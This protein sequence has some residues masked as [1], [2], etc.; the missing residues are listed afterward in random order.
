MANNKNSNEMVVVRSTY[1]RNGKK[2]F[3]YSLNGNIN[4]RAKEIRLTCQDVGMFDVLD[5]IFEVNGKPTLVA[6]PF[7]MK[8]D[9]GKE[10]KGF[11]YEVMTTGEDSVVYR[12][13]VKPSR[14]SDKALLDILHQKNALKI[15]AEEKSE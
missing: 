4:G 1:E 9:D 7:S 11:T 8:G 12:A 10:I 13:K 5:I 2:Y 14:Q 15:L 3:Q 6:I